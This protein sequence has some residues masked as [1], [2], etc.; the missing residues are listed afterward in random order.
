MPDIQEDVY[1]RIK[2]EFH[3]THLLLLAMSLSCA[4]VADKQLLTQDIHTFTVLLNS[5]VGIVFPFTSAWSFLRQQ[6]SI[7][8]VWMSYV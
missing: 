5:E 6:A 3:S 8:C 1:D 4:T 7:G 2:S